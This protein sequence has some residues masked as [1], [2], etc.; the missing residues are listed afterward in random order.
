MKLQ[1][2][3][4][5]LK[6][7]VISQSPMLWAMP[8]SAC[9]RLWPVLREKGGHLLSTEDRQAGQGRRVSNALAE[10]LDAPETGA[11]VE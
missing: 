9:F 3:F 5:K 1:E 8:A 7:K 10:A 2:H 4:S 11:Q 6:S